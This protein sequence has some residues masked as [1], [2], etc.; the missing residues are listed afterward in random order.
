[1]TAADRTLLVEFVAFADER[2]TGRY[3]GRMRESPECF[4]CEACELLARV[5]ADVLAEARQMLR[6]RGV[7]RD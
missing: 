6:E 7:E 4:R 5:P 3:G 2:H 1:M